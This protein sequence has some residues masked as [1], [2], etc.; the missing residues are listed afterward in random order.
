LSLATSNLSTLLIFSKYRGKT[1][2][3]MRQK[4]TTRMAIFIKPPEEISLALNYPTAMQLYFKAAP[5]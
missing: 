1:S 4:A 5:K 3:G 2:K